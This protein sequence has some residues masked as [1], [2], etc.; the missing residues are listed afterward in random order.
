MIV[1]RTA[2]PLRTV[3]DSA[4]YATPIRGSI[5]RLRMQSRCDGNGARGSEWKEFVDT[6]EA[7]HIEIDATGRSGIAPL[8]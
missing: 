6:V 2:N 3:N 5:G 8:G 4:Y 1:E 7:W